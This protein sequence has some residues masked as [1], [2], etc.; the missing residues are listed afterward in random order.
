MRVSASALFWLLLLPA[1]RATAQG[2]EVLR[3]INNPAAGFGSA[4]ACAGDLDGDG[5]DDILV[6]APT[7]PGN[8][9]VYLYSGV[10]GALLAELDGSLSAGLFGQ[11][12]TGLDDADGDSV[13]DFAVG[14][15]G[16]RNTDGGHVF[17]YSGQTRALLRTYA[18]APS[19]R[20]GGR[21]A[22]IRDEDGDG[23]DDFIVGCPLGTFGG[24]LTGGMVRV[25]STASGEALFTSTGGQVFGQLGGSVAD[26][27]DLDT[28]GHSEL[29]VGAAG[30]N[31][32]AGA[33][34]V[35]PVFHSSELFVVAGTS[36]GESFGTAVAGFG[37]LDQDGVP[38]VAGSTPSQIRVY[39]VVTGALLLQLTTGARSMARTGDLDGDSVP[40]VISCGSNGTTV[41]SGSTISSIFT[42]SGYGTAVAACGDTNG[43]GLGEALA[44][45]IG[46]VAVIGRAAG[47]FLTASA[48]TAS[49][50]AGGTILYTLNFPQPAAFQ[51]YQMLASASGTGP[52]TLFGLQVPLTQDLLLDKTLAGTYPYGASNFVATL[53]VSGDATAVLVVGI[54]KLPLNAVGLTLHLAAVVVDSAMNGLYASNAV[55]LDIVP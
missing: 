18:G 34:H 48:N 20:L 31:N 10:T 13:P 2:L 6:G 50:A 33:I 42:L 40:D 51:D 38:E 12:V 3:T 45:R 29:L 28:D 35:Y 37:D 26:A 53:D 1:P 49:Q 55:Q 22:P 9:K 21:L 43:D 15:P 11:A 52:T 8:G 39:S 44:S 27:G 46:S 16:A 54:G 47:D 25:Y 36:P 5:A 17:L 32:A 24:T 41:F 14:A 23:V 7:A 30:E 19:Q 4:I